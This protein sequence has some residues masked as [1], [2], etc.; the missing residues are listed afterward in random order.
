MGLEFL[1]GSEAVAR[2]A[3]AA[4]CGFF[5]DSPIISASTILRHMLD[6]LPEFGSGWRHPG[7][8]LWHH[9]AVRRGFHGTRTRGRRDRAG[10]GG[11]GPVSGARK[12][13]AGG[14]GR[15]PPGILMRGMLPSLAVAAT[16]LLTGP[17]RAQ[18]PELA[19]ALAEFDRAFAESAYSE[20]VDL[21]ESVLT[22]ADAEFGRDDSR[23]VDL[24]LRL[25][26]AH[27]V[28]TFDRERIDVLLEAAW[29]SVV[30]AGGSDHPDLAPVLALRGRYQVRGG[31]LGGAEKDLRRALALFP[32]DAEVP[33]GAASAWLGIVLDARGRPVEA[34][35]AF[36]TAV[37]LF[38]R[39]AARLGVPSDRLRTLA[40]FIAEALS[41][42]VENRERPD[43]YEA[44]GTARAVRALAAMEA[45]AGRWSDAMTHFARAHRTFRKAF[46]ASHPETIATLRL[47]ER[48][49]LSPSGPEERD[50]KH[51]SQTALAEGLA[52]AEARETAVRLYRQVI[53]FREAGDP[54]ASAG[55]HLAGL[56]IDLARVYDA[57]GHHREAAPLYERALPVSRRYYRAEAV[58]YVDMLVAYGRNQA[59]RSR[60]SEAAS[61]FDQAE[62]ILAKIQDEAPVLVRRAE[63]ALAAGRTDLADRG[64]AAA[65]RD[66]VARVRAHNALIQRARELEARREAAPGDREALRDL[67]GGYLS[68]LGFERGG[69]L[70][71]NLFLAISRR[72]AELAA[73]DQAM[74][75]ADR[76]L[77]A[78]ARATLF[79]T[80]QAYPLAERALADS[81][82]GADAEVLRKVLDG[83][84]QRIFET[85]DEFRVGPLDVTAFATVGAAPDD[86]LLWPRFHLVAQR[87]E[88][89]PVDHT[90][91]FTAMSKGPPGEERHYL[92]FNSLNQ[93]LLVAVYG[94]QAPTYAE[95]RESVV[96]VLRGGLALADRRAAR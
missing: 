90:V 21:G 64:E 61:T 28:W 31:D 89:A 95:L 9:R 58:L 82:D 37:D 1:D 59:A 92:Y 80:M 77:A 57:M 24:R 14:D 96:L 19:A 68:L 8:P 85:V 46:E 76:R 48:S 33:M 44:P 91:G 79:T 54:G 15:H 65:A 93:T 45:L 50:K 20:A 88:G 67:L 63:E 12:G 75:E 39:D 42:V 16:V 30:S 29:T 17:V 47:A 66:T 87:G 43:G 34:D 51:S 2:G 38:R 52:A 4:S 81:G 10:V 40:G 11:E 70:G 18:S 55:F 27:V 41:G 32:V 69:G 25:A 6:R 36:A 94:T 71:A 23:T 13:D 78:V 74:D 53:R 22:L 72:V 62:G 35:G 84:G 49:F 56:L 73:D 5:A 3:P 7:R 86:R 26:E 60:L 83:L